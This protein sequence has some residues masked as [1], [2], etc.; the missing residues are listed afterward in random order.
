[1]YDNKW[2]SIAGGATGLAENVN[3]VCAQAVKSGAEELIGNKETLIHTEVQNYCTN[4]KPIETRPVKVGEVIHQ[5]EVVP[6]PDSLGAFPYSGTMCRRF[7]VTSNDT[8]LI[9]KRGVIC[10][11]GRASDDLWTVVDLY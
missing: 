8:A 4:E 6:D 3:D 11:T 5:S 1:L 7:V 10:S 2:E 9:T